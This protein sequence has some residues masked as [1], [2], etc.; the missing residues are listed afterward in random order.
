VAD[1]DSRYIG[2]VLGKPAEPRT[3]KIEGAEYTSVKEWAEKIKG[4]PTNGVATT[5][6][7]MSSRRQSSVLSSLGDESIDNM[8]F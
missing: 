8:E 5:V 1:E 4:S 7:V 3:V 6:S 2:T